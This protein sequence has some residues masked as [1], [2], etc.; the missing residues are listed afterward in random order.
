MGTIKGI[1]WG[2]NNHN[3]DTMAGY[4]GT[5]E[6]IMKSDVRIYSFIAVV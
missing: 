2:H 4:L 1:V 5:G 3:R 6:K